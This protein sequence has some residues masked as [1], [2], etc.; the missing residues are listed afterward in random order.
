MSRHRLLHPEIFESSQFRIRAPKK[1]K[2][3][4]SNYGNIYPIH[5]PT[6]NQFFTLQNNIQ[7]HDFERKN[8]QVNHESEQETNYEFDQRNYY[9]QQ[10]NDD[11]EQVNHDFEREDHDFERENYDFEQESEFESN[12]NSNFINND[13]PK[14]FDGKK[15][16]FSNENISEFGSFTIMAFFI[17]IS[18][19]M[20][21]K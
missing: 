4:S 17:W 7:N 13:D 3:V 11:T 5:L 8:H 21:C 18:K 9:F 1:D 10:I 15:N 20:I 12:L 19:Y 14:V 16:F 6:S 2:Q